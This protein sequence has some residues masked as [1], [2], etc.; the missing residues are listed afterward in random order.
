[1]T[2]LELLDAGVGEVDLADAGRL[3][4]LDRGEGAKVKNLF[5][6]LSLVK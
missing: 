1:M 3:G 6:A 2:E 5:A 4:V